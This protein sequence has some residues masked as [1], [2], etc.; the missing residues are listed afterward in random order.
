V[1]RHTST[2]CYLLLAGS[3]LHYVL[4]V[5]ADMCLYNGMHALTRA[6]QERWFSSLPCSLRLPRLCVFY[7]SHALINK[8]SVTVSPGCGCMRPTVRQ[9]SCAQLSGNC[10]AL[11]CQARLRPVW[12]CCCVSCCVMLSPA[13]G[14]ARIL[15]RQLAALVDELIQPLCFRQGAIALH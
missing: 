5:I 4:Y 6:L 14:D 11:N 10:H 15:P 2:L 1:R 7:S 3:T 12:P 9:L 8:A 13:V